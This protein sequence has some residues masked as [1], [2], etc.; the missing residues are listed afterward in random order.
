MRSKCEA[1]LV[2]ILA[3]DQRRWLCRGSG[4]L[5][6]ASDYDLP[7]FSPRLLCMGFMVNKVT[8]EHVLLLALLFPHAVVI[9]PL[10]QTY[11]ITH[12]R[13]F[14]HLILATESVIQSHTKEI[15]R[16]IVTVVAASHAYLQTG[17][18]RGYCMSHSTLP[19]GRNPVAFNKCR[20][21]H[22]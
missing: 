22:N 4:S 7:G 2:T 14:I 6:L 9:P 19:Q 1:N 10:F 16:G 12:Y 18:V 21:I 11:P 17:I 3:S 13:H 8:W 5:S 20:T 15:E